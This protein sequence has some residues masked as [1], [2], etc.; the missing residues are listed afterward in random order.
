MKTVI[1]RLALLALHML[2]VSTVQAEK[3]YVE[4]D[5]TGNLIV[6]DHPS[7]QAVPYDVPETN[8]VTLPEVPELVKPSH[9][10]EEIISSESETEKNYNS[11]TI[12]SPENGMQ[13]RGVE[14]PTA[15]QVRVLAEPALREGH[16]FQLYIN[17]EKIGEK[18]ANPSF[19]IYDLYR[20]NYK[21]KVAVVD[22]NDKE[23][24][25]SDVVEFNI[26]QASR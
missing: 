3:V 9:D 15:V 25:V 13:I 7:E 20:G 8:T 11:L 21:M 5:E 2:V 1:F 19:K 23:L 14:L 12:A 6:S 10:S 22:E 24:I 16:N 4:K 26:F 18:N 17:N